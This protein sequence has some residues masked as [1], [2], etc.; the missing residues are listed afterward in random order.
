MVALLLKRPNLVAVV[1]NGSIP[2][3]RVLHEALPRS[4]T[5][6]GSH[7]RFGQIARSLLKRRTSGLLHS[8]HEPTSRHDPHSIRDSRRAAHLHKRR[9]RSAQ[10]IHARRR[11]RLLSR[12]PLVHDALRARECLSVRHLSV[13]KLQVALVGKFL[14]TNSGEKKRRRWC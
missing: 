1:Y 6:L 2:L 10:D 14:G 7:H 5:A 12:S 11:A 13:V 8:R 9:R 3:V 4:R